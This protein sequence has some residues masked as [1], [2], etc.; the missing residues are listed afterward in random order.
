[1]TLIYFPPPPLPQVNGCKTRDFDCR[2][3]VPL[4]AEASNKLNLV[5]CRNPLL[6]QSAA[7]RDSLVLDAEPLDKEESRELLAITAADLHSKEPHKPV[8]AA[9]DVQLQKKE[10]RKSLTA[11]VDLM[12]KEELTS[13][14]AV[15]DLQKKE[16]QKWASGLDF[17]SKA[18]L[19]TAVE[20]NQQKASTLPG[21]GRV[22]MSSIAGAKPS[23]GDAKANTLG[24]K[25]AVAAKP[26]FPAGKPP[27]AAKSSVA[28]AVA[29]FNSSSARSEPPRSVLR[30]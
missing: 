15:R 26:S 1:M 7:N 6:R 24:M 8:D 30:K 4:I 20:R 22:P 10:A 5:I 29:R 16:G 25:P 18:E 9:A 21:D 27:V 2:M 28:L 17:E 12:K 11:A 23:T 14:G 3:T 13:V 19:K